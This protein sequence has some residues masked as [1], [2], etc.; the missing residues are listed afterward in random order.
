[1]WNDPS[2]NDLAHRCCHWTHLVS[3]S[4]APA[5]ICLLLS[6]GSPAIA[7]T[8]SLPEY[9]AF[10]SSDL[11]TIARSNELRQ[12]LQKEPWLV[13]RVLRSVDGTV[14]DRKAPPEAAP[15][16]RVAP[17]AADDLFQLLKKAAE[18]AKK[19]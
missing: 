18:G 12:A 6:A 11:D 9:P 4:I 10:S 2:D 3:Q 8:K 13:Y 15:S 19:N 16:Q 17:E 7:D 14:P 1:M 5:A